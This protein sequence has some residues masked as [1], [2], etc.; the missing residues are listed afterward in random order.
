MVEVIT[1]RSIGDTK[2]NE[3]KMKIAWEHRYR[4]V[5]LSKPHSNS[6]LRIEWKLLQL[7]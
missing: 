7:I 3:Q 1:D 6:V 4:A 2:G 5:A